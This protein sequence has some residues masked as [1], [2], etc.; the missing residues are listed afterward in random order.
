M[1]QRIIR[2]PEQLL[3]E[4]TRISTLSTNMLLL[5][6]ER[7][8]Q[9]FTS[10]GQLSPNSAPIKGVQHVYPR[11]G[12]PAHSIIGDRGRND[13]P[14]SSDG[15]VKY[16]SSHLTWTVSEK[17]VPSSHNVQDARETARERDRLRKEHLRSEGISPE[18]PAGTVILPTIIQNNPVR[19]HFQSPVSRVFLPF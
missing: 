13:T 14:H 2:F 8:V 5:N 17:I 12:V 15:V 3:V 11:E 16:D 18:L 7:I 10:I 4:L 9:E 19:Y 1:G 6:P